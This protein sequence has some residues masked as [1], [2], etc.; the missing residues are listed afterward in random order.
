MIGDNELLD[1]IKNTT[2]ADGTDDATRSAWDA[3]DIMFK[4]DV[5]FEN[6]TFERAVAI[7]GNASSKNCTISDKNANAETYMLWI[8]AGSNV[9]LDNC[10]LMARA[11][12]RMATAPLPLRMSML[13][14]PAFP[15]TRR[16]DPFGRP[17]R[18]GAARRRQLRK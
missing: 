16:G 6:V 1:V 17:L 5:A 3:H 11:T 10:T 4:G 2:V 7:N 8:Q 13:P 14:M 12:P 18:R 15:R 9:T